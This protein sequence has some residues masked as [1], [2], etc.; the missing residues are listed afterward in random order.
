MVTDKSMQHFLNVYQELRLDTIETLAEI[1]SDDIHFIDPAHEIKGLPALR[2][3]FSRLY[4]NIN[5]IHFD[6]RAPLHIQ[7]TA[8]VQWCM[9]FSHPRLKSGREIPVDGASFLKFK[10]DGKVCYHRDY[11]DLGSMLYQHLPVIGTIV[12]TINRRLGT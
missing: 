12:K 5:H 1:Y 2:T 4:E 10:A 9:T 3:Y 7:D 6:F 11:F 8:Y